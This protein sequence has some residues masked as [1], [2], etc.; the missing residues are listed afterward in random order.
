M[1]N[2]ALN[3]KQN[4][5]FRYNSLRNFS[6]GQF[7]AEKANISILSLHSS[8]KFEKEL[9]KLLDELVIDLKGLLKNFKELY[10]TPLKKE[11]KYFLTLNKKHS[12]EDFEKKIENYINFKEFS[13]ELLEKRLTINN[14]LVK[15]FKKTNTIIYKKTSF[16]WKE[17]EKIWLQ[18]FELIQENL[19]IL[20]MMK[21]I[22]YPSKPVTKMVSNSKELKKEFRRILG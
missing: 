17:E 16:F 9:E 6:D 15:D 18:S 12:K 1:N 10:I 8:K 19:K 4:N 3:I 11:K 7:L 5:T 20:K 14:D 2:I 22:H 13:K 21:E